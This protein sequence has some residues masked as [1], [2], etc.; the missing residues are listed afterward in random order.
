[1]VDIPNGSIA[2]FE[3]LV[4]LVEVHAIRG[5]YSVRRTI[6]QHAAREFYIAVVRTTGRKRTRRPTH[7]H[8]P[9]RNGIELRCRRRRGGSGRYRAKDCARKDARTPRLD[10]RPACGDVG[11]LRASDR[12]IAGVDLQIAVLGH[13]HFNL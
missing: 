5:Q 2:N 13:V 1:M 6:Q 12:A 3:A 8:R 11:R 9:P 7:S 10:G 4:G